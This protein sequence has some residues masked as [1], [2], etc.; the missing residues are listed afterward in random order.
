[1]RCNACLQNRVAV[2]MLITAAERAGLCPAGRAG[3]K[4][5]KF[6]PGCSALT[7]IIPPSRWPSLQLGQRSPSQVSASLPGS[8]LLYQ[9]KPAC[10]E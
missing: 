5:P 1:M 4:K 9:G 2:N 10:A 6:S 3:H 8:L 7:P